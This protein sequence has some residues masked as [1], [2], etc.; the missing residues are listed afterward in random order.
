MWKKTGLNGYVYGCSID[1]DAIAAGG[2]LD[3]HNYLMKKNEC[4]KIFG[5]VKKFFY[6]VSIFI[7]FNKPKFVELYFYEQSIMQDKTT[8]C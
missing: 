3:I 7:D 1:C 5:L 6:R 2:I 8:N 4:N